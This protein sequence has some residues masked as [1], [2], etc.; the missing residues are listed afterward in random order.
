MYLP[1]FIKIREDKTEADSY[2][3]IVE[4]LNA[5]DEI[6]KNIVSMM[7]NHN[8]PFCEESLYQTDCEENLKEFFLQML[9]M[10]EVEFL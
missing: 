4:S 9:D 10:L 1:R 2:D 3:K 6:I 5:V 7:K 8:V